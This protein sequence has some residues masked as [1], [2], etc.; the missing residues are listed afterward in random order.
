MPSWH[1][2]LENLHSILFFHFTTSEGTG[3]DPDYVRNM[4]T[5]I[6]SLTGGARRQTMPK[7]GGVWA[8]DLQLT[9]LGADE[10][11]SK[12]REYSPSI[13]QGQTLLVQ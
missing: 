2:S 1:G 5:I 3:L 7:H 13:L 10:D 12:N 11:G 4:T 8:R 6:A 9:A